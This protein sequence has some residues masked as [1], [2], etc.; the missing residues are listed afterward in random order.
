VAPAV[1]VVGLANLTRTM[2]AAGRDLTDLKRANERA[3]SIVAAR[4][5]ADAPRATGRLAASV[6]PGKAARKAVVRAG[7]ARVPYAAFVEYGTSKMPGRPFLRTAVAVT[8]PQWLS[9]YEQEVDR[10]VRTIQ[11]E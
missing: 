3:G 7:G 1:E 5:R 9:E 2:R 4:G 11:G 8:Q 10:I 6:R